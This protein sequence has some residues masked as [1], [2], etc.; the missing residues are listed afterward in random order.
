VMQDIETRGLE[1]MREVVRLSPPGEGQ[2]HQPQHQG[3]VERYRQRGPPVAALRDHDQRGADR[4]KRQL[5][6]L[7]DDRYG[8][9]ETI[10][11]A[12]GPAGSSSGCWILILVSL[13]I[14]VTRPDG[15]DRF[16]T[17]GGR[18]LTTHCGESA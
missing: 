2:H 14:K 7:C 11:D 6:T 9:I 1:V 18:N 8:C 15:L 5:L 12:N 4:E 3:G 16:D 10:L 17:R 13:P